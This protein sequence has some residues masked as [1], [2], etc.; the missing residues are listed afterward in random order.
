[1]KISNLD[2]AQLLELVDSQLINSKDKSII[3]L[4]LTC[5]NDW[6]FRTETLLDFEKQLHDFIGG[7]TTLQNIII[8]DKLLDNEINNFQ[9]QQ[10]EEQGLMWK[11]ESIFQLKPVFK[12]YRNGTSLL[13]IINSLSIEKN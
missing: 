1:M 2:L 11:A 6:P 3:E 13:E 9:L 7:N 8:R 4:L 10:I 12:K 5:A